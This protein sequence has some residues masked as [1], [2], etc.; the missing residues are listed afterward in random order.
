M[1]SLSSTTTL[2]TFRAERGVLD[3]PP[4]AQY[5]SQETLDILRRSLGYPTAPW[6]GLDSSPPGARVSAEECPSLRFTRR[7]VERLRGATG[8]LLIPAAGGLL[9]APSGA[10]NRF[11]AASFRGFQAANVALLLS[12][13]TRLGFAPHRVPQ[14]PQKTLNLLG[15]T[16]TQARAT[17]GSCAGF[18]TRSAIPW[19]AATTPLTCT[20]PLPLI[21]ALPVPRRR[22]T[23][24]LRCR[25]RGRCIGGLGF[26]GRTSC[27]ARP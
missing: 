23:P 22:C 4:G 10:L 6:V 8:H 19:Q 17:G 20:H 24:G 11:P 26:A 7:Y 27:P 2:G 5:P 18:L 3:G 1:S 12:Y 16:G 9:S 25:R 14:K 21:S 13:A 15:R